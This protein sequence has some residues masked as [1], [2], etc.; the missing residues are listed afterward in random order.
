MSELHDEDCICEVEAK[1][2]PKLKKVKKMKSV[3]QTSIYDKTVQSPAALEKQKQIKSVLAGEQ[4]KAVVSKCPSIQ[5]FK[6]E[7]MEIGKVLVEYRIKDTKIASKSSDKPRITSTKPMEMPKRLSTC[8][9]LK[10]AGFGSDWTKE[11]VSKMLTTPDGAE[12]LEKV[13]NEYKQ[14]TGKSTL[15]EKDIISCYPN[16][17][18]KSRRN[19]ELVVQLD[20]DENIV[21]VSDKSKKSK[22]TKTGSKFDLE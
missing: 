4:P 17:L 6:L 12:L 13:N 18:K 10:L 20:S 7:D 19:V 9:A 3:L 11:K 16:Y 15:S 8:E 21:S 5:P 14:L 2:A 22:K 1:K